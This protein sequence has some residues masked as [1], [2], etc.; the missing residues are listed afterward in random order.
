MSIRYAIILSKRDPLHE[1]DN[2]DGGPGGWFYSE[3]RQPPLL[4][5][6]H[7]DKICAV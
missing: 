3:V 1:D 4:D 2:G 7:S 5:Q 6:P